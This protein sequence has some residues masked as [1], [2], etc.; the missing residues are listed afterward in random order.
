VASRF[1]G[2]I[3]VIPALIC[4]MRG[5]ELSH[6]LKTDPL[7]EEVMS[8][9]FKELCAEAVELYEAGCEM[10]GVIDKMTEALESV[11]DEN[12]TTTPRENV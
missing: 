9:I 3:H 1:D 12:T 6:P 7:Q 5:C 2:E 4:A 10:D 11:Q 8:N